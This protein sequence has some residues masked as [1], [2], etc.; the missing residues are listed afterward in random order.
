[1]M[2]RIIDI[3]TNEVQGISSLITTQEEAVEVLEMLNSGMV[4]AGYE[5]CFR[6]ESNEN[7]TYL[8]NYR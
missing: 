1:M 5:P 2:Y 7:V 3:D 6:L 8:G 4:E